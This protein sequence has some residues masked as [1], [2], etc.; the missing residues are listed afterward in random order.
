MGRNCTKW[1]APGPLPAVTWGQSAGDRGVGKNGSKVEKKVFEF[2]SA[3]VI[4]V[5]NRS[6]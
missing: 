6:D 5:Q 2:D 3:E 4:Q 1:K